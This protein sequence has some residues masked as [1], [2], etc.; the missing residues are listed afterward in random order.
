M[1]NRNEQ[2][3]RYLEIKEN[4]GLIKEKRPLIKKPTPEQNKKLLE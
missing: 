1:F 4:P 2:R 3:K